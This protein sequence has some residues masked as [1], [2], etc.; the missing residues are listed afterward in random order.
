M[1]YL[2]PRNR[3]VPLRSAIATW[4][5]PDRWAKSDLAIAVAAVVLA[6]SVFLPWFK[7]AIEINGQSTGGTLIQ[8]SGTVRGVSVHHYLWAVFA[9]ALVQFV[10]LAVRYFPGR[11]VRLPGHALFPLVLSG[12]S[13]VIVLAG[14][15]MKPA[16]W[17]G[18]IQLGDG[19]SI[20]IAWDYGALVALGAAVVSLGIAVA[21][22]RDRPRHQRGRLQVVDGGR[23]GVDAS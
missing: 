2:P 15:I 16:A 4:F 3:R 12:L 20:V 5:T 22:I 17:F 23:G 19:F 18:D 11:A 1:T 8:P 10:M 21:A 7:A 9:L 13:F 14:S 6:V